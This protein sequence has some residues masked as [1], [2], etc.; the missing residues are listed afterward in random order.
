MISNIKAPH[1]NTHLFVLLS[2]LVKTLIE[3]V[4]RMLYHFPIFEFRN[5][6]D[7]ISIY[8]M[9]V[10]SSELNVFLVEYFSCV[11]FMSK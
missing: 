4:N 11:F 1:S 6:A 9:I 8:Q 5:E 7:L 3:N 2:I 10:Q